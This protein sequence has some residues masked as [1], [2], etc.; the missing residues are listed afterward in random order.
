MLSANVLWSRDRVHVGE[1]YTIL[2]V[3]PYRIGVIGLTRTPE[4][5]FADLTVLDPEEVLTKV[6]PEVGRQVHT[7]VLLTNLSYRA[8]LDLAQTVPGIDLVIAA[9]PR[10]LPEGAVRAPETGS[11]VVV[12]EQPLPRHSGR[13][14]GELTV[15][16]DSDGTLQ[17]ERWSSIAMGPEYA[18][19]P[20]MR[21]LL[22]RYR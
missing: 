18:D 11:L 1:P 3:G 20:D 17:R 15:V 16:V 9:L 2:Q 22:D 14:V 5:Q 10:Q 12:A 6:V 7:V 8:A 13:R 21:K 19:D 4:A